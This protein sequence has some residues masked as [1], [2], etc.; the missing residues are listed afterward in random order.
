MALALIKR[1]FRQ[2]NSFLV[3]RRTHPN[4][5]H[6]IDT[7]FCFRPTN[8]HQRDISWLQKYLLNKSIQ[9]YASYVRVGNVLGI[10]F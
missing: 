7:T 3:P 9:K 4:W 6:A 1:L 5:T 10:L 2:I 8:K